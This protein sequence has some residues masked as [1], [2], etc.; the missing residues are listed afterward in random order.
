MLEHNQPFI[1]IIVPVY[2]AERSI[3]RCLDT[4]LAQ[5]YLNFELILVND[6]TPD[7]SGEICDDY[8]STDSRI[9]VIHK[10]NGGVSS[11]RN[12]GLDVVKGEWIAF[13]DS[14]DWV[15]DRWL[16]EYVAEIEK[17]SDAGLIYQGVVR[18][19][20]GVEEVDNIPDNRTFIGKDLIFAYLDLGGKLDLFGLTCSKIYRA[21]ICNQNNFR[22]DSSLSFGEDFEFTLRFLQKIDKVSVIKAFNYVY[23]VDSDS[24]L[25][26]EYHS[27][28]DLIYLADKIDLQLHLLSRKTDRTIAEMFNPVTHYRFRA[29]KSLYRPFV[30]KTSLERRTIIKKFYSC[31]HSDLKRV[32]VYDG[33]EKLIVNILSLKSPMLIDLIYIT[34]FRLK[35]KFE[36][37]FS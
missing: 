5:T 11:A 8:A 1:S 7:S 30:S 20:N 6:G 26:R 33:S 19:K 3:R 34:I 21:D 9:K 17:N 23:I 28:D 22:F 25:S 14:D 35:S 29:L 37:L 18:V 4:I 15:R 31:Y 10:E 32:D 27:Y 16:A 13:V 12:M 36:E 24:S 2:N